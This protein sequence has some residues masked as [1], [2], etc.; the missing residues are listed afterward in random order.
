MSR[1][2][3]LSI[4]GGGIRGILPLCALVELEAQIK[5]P[6]REVFSFMAGT[7]T[8]SIIVAG[9]ARGLSAQ[10]ILDIY[11]QL[12]R[13]VFRFD[14]L[15]FLFSLGSFRYRSAPLRAKLVEYLGDPMLNELPIDI[16]LT[17]M[18]VRDGRPFYFV[19]DNPSN[20]QT[21]G[22]LSL[23]DC[24]TGSAAAPTF[25]DPWNVKG[26]GDCVDGGLTIAGNPCYQMCV[27]AFE[28]TAPGAYAPSDA[29]IV[30]LG[31]GFFKSPQRPSNLID[32]VRFTIGQLLD[33]PAEQQTQLVR[34]HFVPQGASLF[35]WNP[36]LPR[37]IEL[38][39][40][41]EIQTLIALGKDFAAELDWPKILAGDVATRAIRRERLPRNVLED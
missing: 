33:E 4:D 40:A 2:N 26:I 27:E 38:D 15:G 37:E 13:D 41:S 8:G 25:F 16:M 28:Y 3:L 14:V 35:R 34:R 31:T 32:W 19:K 10:A 5:K 29:N 12:G 20:T 6:A 9:L 36:E 1:K 18:R 17:A 21:T 39:A 30:A 24:V 11:T 7:S 22:R 23:A